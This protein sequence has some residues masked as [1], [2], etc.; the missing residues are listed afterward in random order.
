MLPSALVIRTLEVLA[1]HIQ[2]S[3]RALVAAAAVFTLTAAATAVAAI[4]DSDGKVD[5][6]IAKADRTSAT[7]L[8]G[9][10]VTLDRRG[11]LRA[12][13]SAAGEQCRSDEQPLA[14]N[15]KG[16]KGDTGPQGER[17]PEGPQGPAGPAGLAGYQVVT[18]ESEMGSTGSRTVVASCPPEKRVIGTGY[19]IK[20]I[21]AFEDVL[22]SQVDP[23]YWSEVTPEPGRNVFILAQEVR[24][25]DDQWALVG[26]AICAKVS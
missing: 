4:P 26:W 21:H 16:Q 17:G 5:A 10:T 2:G 25:T 18:A 20:T 13:D 19:K 11:T 15:V 24:E 1:V 7:G 22:V 8:L 9:P 6:C 14:F 3:R 23:T 12:V